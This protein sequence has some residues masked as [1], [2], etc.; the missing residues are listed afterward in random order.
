MRETCSFVPN[1]HCQ[2]LSPDRSHAE[3]ERRMCSRDTQENTTIFGTA[4][5]PDYK[6]AEHSVIATSGN[7]DRQKVK[8]ILTTTL[9]WFHLWAFQTHLVVPRVTRAVA[10]LS[11]TR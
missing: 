10:S 9:D 6:V 1:G 2:V 4:A 7:D 3:C 8:R 5:S 11:V